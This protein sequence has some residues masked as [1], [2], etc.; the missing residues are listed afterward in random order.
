VIKETTAAEVR[1][2][3]ELAVAGDRATG[4]AARIAG[5]RVAG[6]TGTSDAE[7]IFASFIGIVPADRPRYIIYVGVG[8][9][10]HEGSGGALAAPVFARIARRALAL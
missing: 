6:K 3:L 5:V 10:R 4:K 7:R 9:S 2:L 1:S 8:T